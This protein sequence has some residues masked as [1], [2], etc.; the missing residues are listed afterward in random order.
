MLLKANKT[1][2]IFFYF[3]ILFLINVFDYFVFIQKRLFYNY[4]YII[5]YTIYFI[6]SFF[7]SS[8]NKI[9]NKKKIFKI[10]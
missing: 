10:I 5:L 2:K 3:I 8:I 9:K 4:Y 7:I 1:K 6:F